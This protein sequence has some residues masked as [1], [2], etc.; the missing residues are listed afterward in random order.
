MTD[1]EFPGRKIVFPM[2]LDDRW[3]REALERYMS[4]TQSKAVYLP[5]NIDYLTRNNGLQGSTTDVLEKL[6]GSSWVI[7]VDVFMT[8]SSLMPR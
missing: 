7:R 2:V 5:S 6:M 8:L 1:I 3:S 4:I